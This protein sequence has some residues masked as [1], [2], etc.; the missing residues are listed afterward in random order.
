MV[1]LK[2][3]KKAIAPVVSGE[4][5]E[6]R[7]LE[8]IHSIRL[9]CDKEIKALNDPTDDVVGDLRIC[10]FLRS[11][12]G[13]VEAAKELYRE[14]LQW[15]VADDHKVERIRQKVVGKTPK[16]FLE[17]F[18]PRITPDIPICPYAGEN[19]DGDVIM[20]IRQGQADFH[21]MA[22]KLPDVDTFNAM[23][24]W[25][26]W[27]LDKLSREQE[28][29]AYLIKILDFGGLGDDG[30]GSPLWYIFGY[31]DLQ[32]S[33]IFFILCFVCIPYQFSNFMLCKMQTGS[34][35]FADGC[36]KI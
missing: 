25:Q 31:I 11:K 8:L 2:K 7:E 1:L 13:D 19:E 28:R 35:K 34:P 6:G 20:M 32:Q 12:D 23:L 36:L 16:E 3:K 18:Y 4:L 15:R 27:Y 5:P 33:E 9:A 24:E 22:K 14:F 17:W 10:R 29:I 21:G 26:L 30:R